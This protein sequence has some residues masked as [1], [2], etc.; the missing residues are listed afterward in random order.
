[1][2]PSSRRVRVRVVVEDAG[3]IMP[4]E[5]SLAWLQEQVVSHAAII[6]AMQAELGNLQALIREPSRSTADI[7]HRMS[8]LDHR[9]NKVLALFDSARGGG[10]SEQGMLHHSYVKEYDSLVEQQVLSLMRGVYQGTPG[11]T[12]RDKALFVAQI[13]HALFGAPRVQEQEM[14]DALPEDAAEQARDICARARRLRDK[15]VQGRAQYWDWNFSPGSDI[16][17]DVQEPWAGSHGELVDFVVAP[18]Y[19]VDSGTR[20]GK[21]RVFTVPRPDGTDGAVGGSPVGRPS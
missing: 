13:C 3:R 8:E 7:E 12:P 20:L 21:Q 18:A 19:V 4:I 11:V 9:L 6:E 10:R 17:P 14:I 2:S 1:M 15:A 16:D 5:E